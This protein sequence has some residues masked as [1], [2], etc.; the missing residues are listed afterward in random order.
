MVYGWDGVLAPHRQDP[1]TRLKLVFF[2]DKGTRT[3]TILTM[4]FLQKIQ[5]L[6]QTLSFLGPIIF[7]KKTEL[8]FRIRKVDLG[9]RN[10]YK[11]SRPSADLRLLQ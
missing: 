3:D 9:K 10:T 4:L 6:I 11:P 2:R 7:V 1:S 8:I 5:C